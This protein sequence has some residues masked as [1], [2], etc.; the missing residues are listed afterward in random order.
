MTRYPL[1]Y[2]LGLVKEYGSVPIQTRTLQAVLNQHS[3]YSQII[4]TLTYILPHNFVKL[5]VGADVATCALQSAHT[6]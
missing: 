1:T 6:I 2:K 3:S 4:E 5:S